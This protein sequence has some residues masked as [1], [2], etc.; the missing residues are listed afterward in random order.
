[1]PLRSAQSQPSSPTVAAAVCVAAQ[2][3]ASSTPRTVLPE[4]EDQVAAAAAAAAVSS[5]PIQIPNKHLA[6]PNPGGIMKFTCPVT[7]PA[8]PPDGALAAA[9]TDAKK[10]M[11]S[12]LHP[13]DNYPCLSN[14]P[15][16]YSLDAPGLAAAVNYTARQ[17]LPDI[18]QL[19]PWAHGLH[20]DNTLQLSFFYARKK[21]ARKTPTCFRGTCI[22]KVGRDIN[23]S[24]LKGAITPEEILPPNPHTPGFLCVDPKDGFNVRNFHI[25]VGKFAGLSDI[26]VYGDDDTERAE[27]ERI[28]KRISNAQLYHRSQSQQG[29]VARGFPVY[30]TFV[31]D[32]EYFRLALFYPRNTNLSLCRP[33]FDV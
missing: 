29:G 6:S 19:F 27:V 13:P 4:N 7:P 1:M 14:S 9:A 32:C 8:S 3:V 23:R 12:L 15:P 18:E 30:N 2:D 21:A 5:T 33:V 31:V 24:R 20:P 25:Q 11:E 16:I 17:P 22:V 10:C 26:V 28:A